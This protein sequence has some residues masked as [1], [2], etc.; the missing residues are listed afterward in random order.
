MALLEPNGV[1]PKDDPVETVSL[2]TVTVP[3]LSPK[4][5][6]PDPTSLKSPTAP[7]TVSLAKPTAPDA[8]PSQTR[9]DH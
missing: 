8:G 6:I 2:F 9:L 1:Y 7:P 5:T 3:C 4:P